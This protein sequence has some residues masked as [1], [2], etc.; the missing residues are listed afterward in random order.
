MTHTRT[1]LRCHGLGLTA[2]TWASEIPSYSVGQSYARHYH[3]ADESSCDS[4]TRGAVPCRSCQGAGTYPEPDI[5]AIA[6]AIKG[7]KGLRS[8]RPDAPRAYYVWRMARFHGGQDVTMPVCAM[9]DVQDDP[10]TRELDA[11]A[12]AVAQAVYGTD[13]AA[14]YRWGGLLSSDVPPAPPGLPTSAYP[15]GP[16]LLDNHDEL[17]NLIV[18]AGF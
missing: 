2:C 6:A 8:K 5:Q 1:C 18:E 17:S 13:M 7:R 16:A 12:D 15:C 10:W 4:C 3:P 9:A 11:I 14:A